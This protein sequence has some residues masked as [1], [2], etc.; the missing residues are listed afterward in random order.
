[1]AT[2]RGMEVGMEVGQTRLRAPPVRASQSSTAVKA[3]T[4]A[5]PLSAAPHRRGLDSPCSGGA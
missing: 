5:P 2:R 3:K 1:M 4:S